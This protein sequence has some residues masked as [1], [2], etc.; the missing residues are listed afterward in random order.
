MAELLED[1]RRLQDSPGFRQYGASSTC[2][3]AW[4]WTPSLRPVLTYRGLITNTDDGVTPVFA[5]MLTKKGWI[6][7]LNEKYT[8]NV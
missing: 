7:A 3:L 1:S 5:I 8:V 6:M 2:R 4:L